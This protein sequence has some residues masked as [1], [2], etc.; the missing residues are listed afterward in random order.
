MSGLAAARVGTVNSNRLVTA[1]RDGDARLRLLVWDVSSAGSPAPKGMTVTDGSIKNVAMCWA[2]ASRVVTALRDSSD[3]LRLT[4]WDISADGHAVSRGGTRTGS[5]VTDVAVGMGPMAGGS[6]DVLT[7]ARDRSGNLQIGR[8]PIRSDGDIGE[9]QIQTFGRASDVSVTSGVSNFVAMKDSEDLLRLI[10]FWS[11][12]QRGG[13]G[14]GGPVS[15]VSIHDSVG[16]GFDSRICTATASSPAVTGVRT[17]PL[18]GGRLLVGAGMFKLI[19]WEVSGTS[20]DSALGRTAEATVEGSS[21]IAF[22]VAVASAGPSNV[23]V[24]AFHGRSSYRKLRAKDRGRPLLR[25]MAW[26][27][28][29]GRLNRIASASTGGAF[30]LLRLVSLSPIDGRERVAV[31][32]RDGAENLRVQVWGL[33]P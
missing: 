15:K 33:D 14:T 4:T 22:E 13:A 10:H 19:H 24:T 11:P 31:V 17:G 12:L 29:D 9:P 27:V 8:W 6:P 20:L 30:H 18:G 16:G 3:A 25:V 23:F 7:A 2:G 5:P 32:A 26:R 28:T 21:G 1:M